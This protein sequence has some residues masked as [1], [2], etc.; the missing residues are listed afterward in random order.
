MSWRLAQ[1]ARRCRRIVVREQLQT[2]KL[3]QLAKGCQGGNRQARRIRDWMGKPPSQRGRRMIG[4]GYAIG[5]EQG[6]DRGNGQVFAGRR[7]D[8]QVS[9]LSGCVGC[10]DMVRPAMLAHGRSNVNRMLVYSPRHATDFH[11][12]VG[13]GCNRESLGGFANDFRNRCLPDR[14]WSRGA[15]S[16]RL[17]GLSITRIKSRMQA[18]AR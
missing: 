11:D 10:T 17:R 18:P 9:W 1:T 2:R 15:L 5:E 7:A 12:Q 13:H 4:R 3:S 8:R 14:D 16:K 6:R